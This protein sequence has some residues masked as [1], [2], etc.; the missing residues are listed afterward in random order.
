[1]K[2]GVIQRTV[3]IRKKS[4]FVFGRIKVVAIT[5]SQ[6]TNSRYHAV[7]QY[8]GVPD[9][10]LDKGFYLFDLGSTH[11]TFLNKS[12]LKP[13]VYVRIKV[14]YLNSISYFSGIGNY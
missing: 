2:S 8:R 6:S 11:G 3:N 4:C 1:M 12:K 14:K 10:E 9:G 7:L 5:R 13:K